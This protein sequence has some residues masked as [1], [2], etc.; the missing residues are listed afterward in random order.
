M[1]VFNKNANNLL[2][3]LKKEEGK[4]FDVHDYMSGT[5]VDTLLGKWLV[6]YLFKQ[7][8]KF[9]ISEIDKYKFNV[10]NCVRNIYSRIAITK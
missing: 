10:I 1:P 7:N 4:V 8:E 3:N 2:N 5:T 6:D 9:A